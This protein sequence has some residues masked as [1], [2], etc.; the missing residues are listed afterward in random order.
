MLVFSQGLQL[1][2]AARKAVPAVNY[3]LGVAGVVAS[4]AIVMAFFPGHGGAAVIVGGAVFVGMVLLFVFS[5]LI[6]SESGSTQMAG[7]VLIW[8]VLVFFIVML[9]SVGS[10]AI[11]GEP[12]TIAKVL[13]FE[14][15]QWAVR[16]YNVDQAEVVMLNGEKITKA[17]Y[18]DNYTVNI[19]DLV[20]SGKNT[21]KLIVS[22]RTSDGRTYNGV[23]YGIEV[24]RDGHHVVS[25]ECGQQS[26]S[27]CP[28]AQISNNPIDVETTFEAN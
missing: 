28:T 5:R 1:I 16:V 6:N 11:F 24:L 22:N 25:Q 13:G 17:T 15:T 3:A 4:G 9:T 2:N 26:V 23:T 27:Y 14:P 18:G 12:K 20:Q 7:Q 19:S 8:A 10:A 21:I